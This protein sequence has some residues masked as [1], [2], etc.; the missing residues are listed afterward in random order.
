M[1]FSEEP[2]KYLSEE[3]TVLVSTSKIT[4]K[5]FTTQ[6]LLVWTVLNTWPSSL[7]RVVLFAKLGELPRLP[8]GFKWRMGRDF[9][10]Q[11]AHKAWKVGNRKGWG[12][13][14]D[15]NCDRWFPGMPTVR[16]AKGGRPERRI[17]WKGCLQCVPLKTTWAWQKL[18]NM[19]N[20]NF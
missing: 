15:R 6:T 16:A 1:L 11:S 7:S 3:H 17:C 5:Y 10:G 4:W 14:N 19:A 9:S 12:G 13:G 20:F 8:R 2:V 18:M